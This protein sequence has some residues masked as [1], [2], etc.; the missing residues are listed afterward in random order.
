MVPH[1]TGLGRHLRRAFATIL[2][3]HVRAAAALPEANRYRKHFHA[4]AHL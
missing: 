3:P 2:D 1:P 4:A